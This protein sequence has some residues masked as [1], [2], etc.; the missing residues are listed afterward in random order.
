MTRDVSIELFSTIKSFNDNIPS[1][2]TGFATNNEFLKI[3]GWLNI[4]KLSL[5]TNKSD[6]SNE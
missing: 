6:L 2:S 3:M 1:K 4:N 5:N